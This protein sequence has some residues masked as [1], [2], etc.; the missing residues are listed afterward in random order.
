M[1]VVDYYSK[2]VE[3]ELQESKSSSCVILHLKSIF[4]RH[5][6]PE[7]LVGNN[8]Q[9]NSLE[10]KDFAMEYDFK[11]YHLHHTTTRVTV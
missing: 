10:F 11:F 2:Y 3:I 5:G 9:F 4:A 8:N 7:E 6:I 1:I